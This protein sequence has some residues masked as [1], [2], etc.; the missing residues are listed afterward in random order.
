GL[1]AHWPLAKLAK[2]PEAAIQHLQQ[3]ASDQYIYVNQADHDSQ[4]RFFYTDDFTDKNFSQSPQLL[5]TF[6]TE[7]VTRTQ[8]CDTDS[9]FQYM[10]STSV[11]YCFPNLL[12]EHPLPI[13]LPSPLISA[14]LGTQSVAAT[15]FDVPQNIA[16]NVLGRRRFTLFP[17]EQHNNLYIGPLDFTP[18]GQPVSLVDIQTPDLEKYPKF[19]HAINHGY[20]VT[21]EP[22]DALFIPSM[23]WHNVEALDNVNLLFNYWWHSSPAYL[24]SPMDALKHAIL[25]IKSLPV[26]QRQAWKVLFSTYVFDHQAKQFEHIPKSALG[27]LDDLIGSDANTQELR[28]RQ[29]RADLLKALNK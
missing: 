11:D 21:L 24:G 18:A 15:H 25:S 28:A 27:M 17:P 19:S 8:G 23:W 4:G 12:L 9:G 13:V 10:A 16:C 6:L 22:G 1:V 29:I 5:K 3:S 2:T 7:L 26:E 14:W 20:Q